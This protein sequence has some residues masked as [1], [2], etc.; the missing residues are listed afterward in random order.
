[1]GL[2]IIKSDTAIKNIFSFENFNLKYNLK[3]I[4]TKNIKNKNP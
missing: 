4:R 1:M 2:I 3:I